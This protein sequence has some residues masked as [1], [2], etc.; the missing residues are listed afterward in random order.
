MLSSMTNR[1]GQARSLAGATWLAPLCLALA[2]GL[3]YL[4]NLGRLPQP[5]E[6]HHALA[7]RGLLANGVPSIAE[8]QY[9]RVLLHSWMVAGAYA[10]F[11][12]SLA[13]ARLPSVLCMAVL[14]GLMFVWLRREAGSPAAWIGTVLFA[15]SP[16]AVDTAQ[17]ARFYAPQCLALFV[18]AMLIHAAVLERTDQP[19]GIVLA[20]LALPPLLLAIYF[21]PTTLIGMAGIGLWAAGA[22]LLPWLAD[23]NVPLARRLGLTLGALALGLALIAAVWL[24]GILDELWHR[25]RWTPL[26]NRGTQDQ[27]WF[28][29]AWFS[30]LY[31]SLWPLTGILGL[32]AIVHRPRPAAFA[33]TVFAMAFLLNSIAAAKSLRYIVY[34]QPFLFS[35]WG[36]ALAALWQALGEFL[37]RLRQ[38]LS[39][40]LAD[41]GRP[42]RPVSWLLL[43]GAI[44]FL[45]L[46]NPTWL[47]T[48]ALLADITIP[49]EV[50]MADWPRARPV[51][52]PW[53]ATADVVVTT[54]ELASLYFLGRYDLRFSRSK[55]EEL[56]D[57]EQKEFGIDPRTGRP[58]ISTTASL[59]RVL[60]CYPKGIILGPDTSWNNPT[61]L[62]ADQVELIK[63]HARPL[64]LPPGSHMFAYVWEQTSGDPATAD[65]AVLPRLVQSPNA[66]KG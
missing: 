47:R 48:T 33:L 11:G 12:D 15:L 50:P 7:A 42:Y 38:G 62:D 19:R 37:A 4:V 3:L 40:R 24:S 32:V 8:G 28:Y 39:D 59:S 56:P 63:Q 53:L 29:H 16:F 64:A 1:D 2:A 55:L 44:L 26:F 21:Q 65:C 14:V 34:A 58:V 46:G 54:E 51:L 6:L 13:V 18:A 36:I 31:P 23:A 66:A 9:D 17:F 30:L 22:L 49:P 45:L 25:Y 20:G 43:A 27:F 35:V 57:A 5:D 52:E 41:L 60:A 10:L 61:L